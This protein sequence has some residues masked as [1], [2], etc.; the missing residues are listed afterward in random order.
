MDGNSSVNRNYFG[1]RS[2]LFA[3]LRGN[4]IREMHSETRSGSG[5]G[6]LSPDLRA[7][8]RKIAFGFE[9]SRDRIA[10]MFLLF[11]GWL[12][13]ILALI[14]L[15]RDPILA[16]FSILILLPCLVPLIKHL[17]RIV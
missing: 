3:S 14:Y 13:I 17:Y 12:V 15:I 5:I 16:P 2:N 7:V 10:N 8:R 9:L 1:S 4:L 11:L 6:I